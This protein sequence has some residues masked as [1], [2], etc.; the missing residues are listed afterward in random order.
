MVDPNVKTATEVDNVINE[1]L[2]KYSQIRHNKDNIGI[3][4]KQNQ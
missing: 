1:I 2:L 3:K 4:K